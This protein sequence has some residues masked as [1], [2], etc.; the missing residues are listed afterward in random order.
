MGKK[1]YVPGEYR[2]G[3]EC[4]VLHRP[5]PG[6]EKSIGQAVIKKERDRLV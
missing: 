2:K 6:R 5:Y 4:P 3:I 1:A